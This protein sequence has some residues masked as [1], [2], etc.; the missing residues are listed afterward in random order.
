MAITITHTT[1]ATGTDAGNGEIR[2]A[3]WNEAHT[4][5]GVPELYAQSGTAVSVSAV[6]TEETLAT[7][8]FSGG[9]L[10]ANGW[11]RVD[12]F[13]T[14]NNNANT[15]TCRIRIG[16]AAGTAMGENNAANSIWFTRT[17]WIVNSN[18]VSVQKSQTGPASN[19]GNG[20]GT[21]A[22]AA[23][24]VNTNAAWDLV[25]T[26]QKPTSAADTVTLE[27]YQVWVCKKA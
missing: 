13:W 26:G 22:S 25:F 11:L 21:S 24:T 1:V 10:G 7:V 23:G 9:E 6:T 14:V 17:T 16:G 5:T 15:K 20:T 8:S 3:Q 27:G 2:K 12:A 4:V 19:T 18:S